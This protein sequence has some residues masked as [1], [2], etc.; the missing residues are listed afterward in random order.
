MKLHWLLLF[1]VV[2]FIVLALVSNLRYNDLKR[3]HQIELKERYKQGFVNGLKCSKI[4]PKQIVDSITGLIY[5][6]RNS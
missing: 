4:E 2:F 6:L 1:L 3:K 5:P